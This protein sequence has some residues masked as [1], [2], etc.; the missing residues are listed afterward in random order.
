MNGV[1]PLVRNVAAWLIL[2]LGIGAAVVVVV[3]AQARADLTDERDAR[4]FAT[5]FVSPVVQDVREQQGRAAVTRLPGTYDVGLDDPDGPSES[6]AELAR[7]T[8]TPALD[9]LEGRSGG[10]VVVA[11]YDPPNPAT[12]AERRAALVGFA[13]TP[14]DLSDSMEAGIGDDGAVALYG[15]DALVAASGDFDAIAELSLIHI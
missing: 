11:V 5:R 15:P 12:V 8:G 6:V 4:Q 13:L 2:L 1:S 7:D 14:F 10:A 9:D 3:E